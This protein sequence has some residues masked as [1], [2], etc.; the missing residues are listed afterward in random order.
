MPVSPKFVKLMDAAVRS[1]YR[2][3]A[4]PE[5]ALSIVKA[6]W[7]RQVAADEAKADQLAKCDQN[8]PN[9]GGEEQRDDLPVPLKGSQ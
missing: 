7:L 4:P 3:G 6:M 2:K 1:Q 5:E 8:Q 9:G